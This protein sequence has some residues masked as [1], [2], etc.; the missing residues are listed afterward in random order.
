MAVETKTEKWIRYLATTLAERRN[1]EPTEAVLMAKNDI[2]KAEKYINKQLGLRHKKRME[3][4]TPRRKFKAQ[5]ETY[6][7][8]LQGGA[9]G[10]GKGK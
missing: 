9:P 10:L 6:G 3:K 1:V 4:L 5:Y 7:A 2:A 8:P